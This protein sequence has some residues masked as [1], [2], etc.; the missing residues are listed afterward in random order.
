M[1][2]VAAQL[3]ES[4]KPEDREINR[5]VAGI[6]YIGKIFCR[7]VSSR[8]LIHSTI[9]GADTVSGVVSDLRDLF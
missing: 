3:L 6:A 7:Y 2:C 5:E 8:I 9:G 4:E 1:P